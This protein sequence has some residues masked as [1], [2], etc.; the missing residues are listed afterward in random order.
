MKLPEIEPSALAKKV[1]LVTGA[2][3]GIGKQAAISYA[4]HG[5]TVILLGKTQF[6][7]EQTYDEII[8]AGHAEPMILPLD[9]NT[10]E[11]QYAED[12][13]DAIEQEF[14]QL[15]GL[16]HNASELGAIQ[17]IVNINASEFDQV[18]QVN[19]RAQFFLTRSLIPLLLKSQSGSVVFT[20]SSVAQQARAYWG[21]YCM[22]KFASD[23]MMQLL[24]DEY[25]NTS[26]RFNSINPG[27]TRT[28]MRAKAYPADSTDLLK[29]PE[30]IMPSYLYLM[31][32]HS[33]QLNGK[34]INA[35]PK[36]NAESLSL[37][38]INVD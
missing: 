20:S 38:I 19:F 6:K 3:D 12:L 26:I 18:M 25:E 36:A 29:T 35:Q 7:L 15:D 13:A 9:L 21:T 1:I 8:A 33:H 30:E 32:D 22:S 24:A 10:V 31:S 28:A 14:G 5:A 16:L 34:I 4:Q 11:Q 17:P 27:A 23:G 37:P 2:G